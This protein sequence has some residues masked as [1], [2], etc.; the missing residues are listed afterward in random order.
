MLSMSAEFVGLLD[1]L[2]E[3]RSSS[4]SSSNKPFLLLFEKMSS[5][6]EELLSFKG[7]SFLDVKKKNKT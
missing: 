4:S 6:V 3:N 2:D 5:S 7:S 1:E